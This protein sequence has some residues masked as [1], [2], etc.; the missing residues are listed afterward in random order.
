VD[1]VPQLIRGSGQIWCQESAQ[2]KDSTTPTIP[3][4]YRIPVVL[5]RCSIGDTCCRAAVAIRYARNSNTDIAV[6]WPKSPHRYW[7]SRAI[8]DHTVLPAT[9][10]RWHSSLYPQPKLVLDLATSEGCK[11]ELTDWLRTVMVYPPKD[12][13]PSKYS[14]GPS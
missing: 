7:N 9:R 14:P 12:G 2:S 1:Y 13:H 4:I 3:V 11:A 10:Q 8:W 5:N 6:R